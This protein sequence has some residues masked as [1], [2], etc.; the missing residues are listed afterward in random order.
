MRKILYKGAGG[1]FVLKVISTGLAFLTSLLLARMLGVKGFG[2][3]SYAISW[4]MLLS[5]LSTMGFDSLLIRNVAVYKHKDQ[6]PLLHGIIRFSGQIVT[7]VSILLSVVFFFIF[8]GIYDNS[9]SIMVRTTLF[10]LLL[11]PIQSNTALK[12][13]V[14]IGFQKVVIAQLPEM[15]IKPL[16]FFFIVLCLYFVFHIHAEAIDIITIYI[17]LSTTIFLLIGYLLRKELIASIKITPKYKIKKWLRSAFTLMLISSMGIINT[18][19]DIV[20]LGIIKSAEEVG[21]YSVATASAS[22]VPFVLYSV[23]MSFAPIISRLYAS[24]EMKQLQREVTHSARIIFIFSL[25]VAVGLIVFG[26]QVLTLFGYEFVRGTMALSILSFGQLINAAA[27]SVGILL[28]MTGHEKEAS[29]GF[30]IGALLN[31]ILNALL[32]PIWS[33][34]GAAISTAVCVIVWNV[35]LVWFVWKRLGIHSTA[36]GKVSLWK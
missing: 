34:E 21:I 17:I 32:I 16:L 29:I 15:L 9:N 6:K 27:G 14:L 19:T 5:I 28:M 2:S 3:Y 11:V 33:I 12:R 24:G 25:P 10:A 7:I 20:M 23:N 13:S 8:T 30:G 26:K 35:I 4:A 18:R 31:I 22:L 36:L 1:T